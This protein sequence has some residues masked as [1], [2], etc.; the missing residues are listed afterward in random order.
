MTEERPVVFECEGERLL[1]IL[2]AGRD[3]SVLGVVIVVGGPQYRVGA[4][5]QFVLMARA[6]AAAGFAVL[7]F[8]YRGMG[9][10]EG[11]VRP[12]DAVDDD[13]R[14][15]VDFLAADQPRLRSFVIIGLCDAASASMI[16][17]ATDPR[18]KGQVLLNPW[19]RSER[20]E[21]RAYVKRYYLQRLMQKS[22]WIKLF[23]GTADVSRSL[24][25]FFS[26]I[27][28]ASSATKPAPM[29]DADFV[30]RMET[31]L[32]GFDGANLILISEH[33][34]TAAEFVDLCE[35]DR[36][37][38]QTVHKKN[39]Q[40]QNVSGADHTLA[41]REKLA[42]VNSIMVDWLREL[43]PAGVGNTTGQTDSTTD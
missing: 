24:R 18:V 25:E 32:Q 21:A 8:D 40:F 7:R 34:L 39:T 17:A 13:I 22:F 20:G 43:D 12:F 29:D 26:T 27:R 11:D 38:K 31:G 30:S 23:S 36:R 9:D 42:Y 3:N 37:W 16:Y 10:A 5:R 15:A 41:R 6:I 4:H 33:D 14:A 35:T 19:V 28:K 2:H 1:G